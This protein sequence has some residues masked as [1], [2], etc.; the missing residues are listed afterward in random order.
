MLKL[1]IVRVQD[2]AIAFIIR[3]VPGPILRDPT[4]VRKL[5]AI[6][7]YEDAM[8]IAFAA[9]SEFNNVQFVGDS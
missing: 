3:K 2:I 5:A 1:N 4:L 6:P 9:Y 8:A 7:I